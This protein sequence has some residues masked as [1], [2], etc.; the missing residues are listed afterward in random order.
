MCKY[1]YTYIFTYS[2]HTFCGIEQHL[3]EMKVIDSR[4]HGDLHGHGQGGGD[5]STH[6]EI[7][8]ETAIRSMGSV[9]VEE[10]TKSSTM[11]PSM[12]GLEEFGFGLPSSTSSSAFSSLAQLQETV[13]KAREMTRKAQV[14]MHIHDNVQLYIC[15]YMCMFVYIYL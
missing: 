1:V 7:G 9:S 11:L 12:R 8:T 3:R 13:A 15:L 10:S 5:A 6:T 14:H 4:N 2:K